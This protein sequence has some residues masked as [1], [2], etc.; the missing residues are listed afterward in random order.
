M[1]NA[2]V[3]GRPS[4][5]LQTVTPS[6]RNCTTGAPSG[7]SP[8]RKCYP[9]RVSGSP[10]RRIREKRSQRGS[11]LV[12]WRKKRAPRRRASRD[13]SRKQQGEPSRRRRSR[14]RG[15]RKKETRLSESLEEGPKTPREIQRRYE[16]RCHVPGGV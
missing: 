15:R 11:A 13:R 14:G 2:I 8:T 1:Q 16:Q 12:S 9:L 7:E 6:R 4:P 3:T 10:R 5:R